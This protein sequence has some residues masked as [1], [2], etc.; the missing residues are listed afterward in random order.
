[1]DRKEAARISHAGVVSGKDSAASLLSGEIR[2]QERKERR[3][4]KQG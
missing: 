1:M 3:L 2:R 4:E